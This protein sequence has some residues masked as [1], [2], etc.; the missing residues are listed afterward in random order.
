MPRQQGPAHFWVDLIRKTFRIPA[1]ETYMYLNITKGGSQ[2]LFEDILY[3]DGTETY[4]QYALHT[5]NAELI[6]YLLA[7]PIID[8]TI[9]FESRE[10]GEIDAMGVGIIRGNYGLIRKLKEYKCFRPGDYFKLILLVD[11][12]QAAKLLGLDPLLLTRGAYLGNSPRIFE[13]FYPLQTSYNPVLYLTAINRTDVSIILEH[14]RF[15]NQSQIQEAAVYAL[16]IMREESFLLLFNSIKDPKDFINHLDV[17]CYRYTHQILKE[18]NYTENILLSP[19]RF[20]FSPRTLNKSPRHF[21]RSPR[22]P[23]LEDE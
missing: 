4:Y 18:N 22:L 3:V 8:P 19:R 21:E 17:R 14:M 12:P 10:Y 9:R 1:V 23:V 7:D 11:D 13:Y 2:D 15:M 6:S 5:L 16:Q 20:D